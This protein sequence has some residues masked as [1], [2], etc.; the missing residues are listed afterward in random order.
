MSPAK[1]IADSASAAAAGAD[2]DP[3]ALKALA[4][5]LN[6]GGAPAAAP[7]ADGPPKEAARFA[8]YVDRLR[9][10]SERDQVIS[11]LLDCAGE[12]GDAAALFVQQ[13]KQL[14][15]LDG[16]GPDHI[17]MSLKW[18]SIATDEPSPFADV[19]SARQAFLGKLADTPA[20][21]SLKTSLGSS[22]GA[23]LYLPLT[24]G[25]RSIGVLYVDELK[26]DLRPQLPGL[27]YLAQEAGGAFAR[28]I[29][30]SKKKS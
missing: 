20:N 10:A 12:L 21:Q 14:A 4:R 15:C 29:L 2:V 28:I 13:Q 5:A 30:A 27:Q 22:D 16:R 26:G 1:P 19:M 7:A 24:V 17:V 9:A 3:Q 11:T 25:A 8:K 18:F 6:P 23:Q